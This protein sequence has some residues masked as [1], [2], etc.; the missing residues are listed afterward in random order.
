M[1]KVEMPTVYRVTLVH[2]EGGFS[3][4]CDALPGCCSQGATRTEALANI[5]QAIRERRAGAG[6]ASMD[7]LSL[8]MNPLRKIWNTP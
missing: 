1:M 8:S 7:L 4:W 3:V 5:R 6:L 2:S